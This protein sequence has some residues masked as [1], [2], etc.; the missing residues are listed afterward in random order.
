MTKA[1]GML[2]QIL[3]NDRISLDPLSLQFHMDDSPYDA[4][5]AVAF[6]YDLQQ[7]NKHLP[8]SYTHMLTLARIPENMIVNKNAKS[9]VQSRRPRIHSTINTPPDRQ[10]GVPPYQY[11]S[12]DDDD[13]DEYEDAEEPINNQFGTGGPGEED[14]WHYTF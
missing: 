2:K 14:Q 10:A 13:E 3:Q 8:K 12:D 11:Q 6:L 4:I 7:N 1:R 9:I 5:D